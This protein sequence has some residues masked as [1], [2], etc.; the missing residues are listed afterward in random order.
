M[1]PACSFLAFRAVSN[2]VTQAGS[3]LLLAGKVEREKP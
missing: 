3:E 2:P 1:D